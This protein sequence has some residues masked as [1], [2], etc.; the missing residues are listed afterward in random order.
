MTLGRGLKAR[1]IK[2]IQHLADGSGI[3]SHLTRE[4]VND[5][6]DVRV[7]IEQPLDIEDV[8]T[9]VIYISVCLLWSS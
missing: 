2:K 3:H 4:A 5:K 6:H 7:V 1:P 8:H 9:N